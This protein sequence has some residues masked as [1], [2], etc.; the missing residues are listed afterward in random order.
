MLDVRGQPLLQRLVGIFRDAGVRD[1]TVVRGYKK[2]AINLPSVATV[3]NDF[4]E[5]T[6]E[7]AS[8]M[9]ALDAI[10][11]PTYVA[12]GD[13]LFRHYF[14][15]LLEDA[16]AD[17]AVVADA[18][19]RE[20][21]SDADGWVRDFVSCT[22]PYSASY[23][24]QEPA[25]LKSAG[26]DIAEDARDAEWTGLVRFSRKGAERVRAELEA[27]QADNTLNAADLP[28]LLTRLAEAGEK[29]AVVYVTGQWLDVDDYADLIKAGRFL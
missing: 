29:I 3:D 5:R 24:D 6:G 12:Y 18:G 27:M 13:I 20:R 1:V 15:D 7:A 19:W 28:A 4:H 17:I 16:E 26:D 9:C 10:E 23:L 2:D 25:F 8:L 22:Q 11:G 14:I 21:H